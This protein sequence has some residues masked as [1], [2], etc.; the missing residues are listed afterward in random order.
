MVRDCKI[1][2][3]KVII[4]NIRTDNTIK[5]RFYSKLR[6]FIRKIVKN[7]IN[8][9]V[10]E[11]NNLDQQFYNLDMIYKLIIK[12]NISFHELSKDRIIDLLIKH[13]IGRNDSLLGKKTISNFN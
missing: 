10:F 11:E 4:F 8:E 13:N 6:K 1:F 9:N 2:T 5:N 3:W 12:N 7:L